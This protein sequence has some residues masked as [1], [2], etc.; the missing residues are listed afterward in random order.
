VTSRLAGAALQDQ[1]AV[2]CLPV[3]RLRGAWAVTRGPLNLVAEE[4]QM[5]LRRQSIAVANDAMELMRSKV[6]SSL[7]RAFPTCTTLAMHCCVTV[8]LICS[9]S[10]L[11]DVAPVSE[12]NLC[13]LIQQIY[14]DVWR[15]VVP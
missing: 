15:A 1:R 2:R 14:I 12:V 4:A 3:A 13:K 10:L 5:A 11:Q 7:L 6:S 8:T 9:L